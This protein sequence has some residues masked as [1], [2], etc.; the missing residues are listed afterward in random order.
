MNTSIPNSAI[1]SNN[2]GIWYDGWNG[3]RI[4]NTA[5]KNIDEHRGY[6]SRKATII[7]RTSTFFQG[8]FYHEIIRRFGGMPYIKKIYNPEEEI[9][10]TRLSYQ[11]TVE[12][13]ATD[14]DS[15]AKLLPKD[16]SNSVA[17]TNMDI[18]KHY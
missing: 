10:L 8:F 4:A 18:K 14:L 6:F 11:A 3:I 9:D 13:I 1:E 15:P 7:N 5:L 17:A 2:S 12:E 16:S